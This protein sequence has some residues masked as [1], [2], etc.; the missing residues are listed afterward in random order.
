[1]KHA[2]KHPTMIVHE[3]RPFNSEPPLARL[4]QSFLTPKNLF[5]SRNHGSI[6]EVDQE[7][8]R[9]NVGGLVD[10]PLELSMGTCTGFPGPR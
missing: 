7:G 1:M 4:R 8:Y 6:P 5:F 9:L 2:G 10:R 3:E